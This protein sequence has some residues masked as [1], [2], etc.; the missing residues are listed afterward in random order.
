LNES[1]FTY[2]FIGH[3]FKFSCQV[4]A[5]SILIILAFITQSL[6][7]SLIHSFF[8]YSSTCQRQALHC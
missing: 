3:F 6:T 8:I 4:N 7:H 1:E 5:V 2:L